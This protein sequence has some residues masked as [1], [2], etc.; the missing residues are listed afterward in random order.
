MNDEV[1]KPTLLGFIITPI[2]QQVAEK[3]ILQGYFLRFGR[4]LSMLTYLY[5][6]GAILG[7]A[8]RN[9][10][11]MLSKMI[12]LPGKENEVIRDFEQIAAQRLESYESTMGV[13]RKPGSFWHFI[14]T[15]ECAKGGIPPLNSHMV[16]LRTLREGVFKRKMPYNVSLE[17]L[18]K[19]FLVEAIAFGSTFPDLAEYMWRNS[20]EH[21]TAD[22]LSHYQ[23]T[24]L[25]LFPN[26]LLTNFEKQEK[27]VL[28]LV[29]SYAS[30]YYPSIAVSLNLAI[31]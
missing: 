30:K 3:G 16:T 25:I 21:V 20:Y 23:R 15:T 2:V 1:T 12:A 26:G 11:D 19:G 29:G 7:R 22:E 13:Y 31:P 18:I 8:K 27:M 5:E 9:E 10:L 14:Y 28:D 4:Y 6:V 24:G 17:N